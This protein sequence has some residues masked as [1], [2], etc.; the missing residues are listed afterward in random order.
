MGRWTQY[1]EDDHRLPEDV[2]RIGYDADSERYYFRDREGLVYKGPKGSSAHILRLMQCPKYLTV[3]I[4]WS[5]MRM[6]AGTVPGEELPV[7]SIAQ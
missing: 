3:I 1:D 7:S 4:P 2:K 6:V 5:R